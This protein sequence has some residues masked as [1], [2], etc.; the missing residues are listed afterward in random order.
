M[1]FRL[2]VILGAGGDGEVTARDDAAANNLK[3]VFGAVGVQRITGDRYGVVT[4][5][6]PVET[7]HFPLQRCFNRCA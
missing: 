5:P 2:G 4:R 1:S 6:Q 7:S 3:Q